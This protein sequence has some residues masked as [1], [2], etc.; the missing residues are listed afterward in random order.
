MNAVAPKNSRWA[1]ACGLLVAAGATFLWWPDRERALAGALGGESAKSTVPLPTEPVAENPLRKTLAAAGATTLTL[2]L[3]MVGEIALPDGDVERAYRLRVENDS[4]WRPRLQARLVSAGAGVAVIEGQAD[5]GDLAPGARVLSADTI[6]LRH[7]PQLR[8]DSTLLRWQFAEIAGSDAS[9]TLLSG[10]ARDLAL[11]ALRD[12]DSTRVAESPAAATRFALQG[13]AIPQLS[14][15]IASDATV[16][17]VNAALRE[18]NA[19]IV[20]M[21]PG[22]AAIALRLTPSGGSPSVVNAADRLHDSGAFEWVRPITDSVQAQDEEMP[23]PD[24][25]PEFDDHRPR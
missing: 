14:A 11:D 25:E 1:L 24:P 19:L 10:A 7:D 20:Q 15:V 13:P 5:L 18:S 9:G 17:T 16:A 4:E 2:S 12:Y 3:E 22:S 23:P 8:I 21:R 6:T